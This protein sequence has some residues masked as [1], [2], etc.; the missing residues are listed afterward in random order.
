MNSELKEK[1]DQLWKMRLDGVW[2]KPG[3]TRGCN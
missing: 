3:D 2:I 1:I